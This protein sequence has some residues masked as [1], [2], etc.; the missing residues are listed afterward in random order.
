MMKPTRQAPRMGAVGAAIA[1]GKLLTSATSVAGQQRRQRVPAEARSLACPGQLI[2]HRTND[3]P[4]LEKAVAVV[5][6]SLSFLA[7]WPALRRRE[8]T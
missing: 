8:A 1:E 3:D 7:R 6:T 5:A 2:Y 4:G